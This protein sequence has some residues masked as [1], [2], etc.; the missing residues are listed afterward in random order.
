[1]LERSL[2]AANLIRLMVAFWVGESSD[3]FRGL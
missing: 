1:M 2:I 3:E